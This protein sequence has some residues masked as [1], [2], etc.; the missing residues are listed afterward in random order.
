MISRPQSNMLL[1]VFIFAILIYGTYIVKK[2]DF[3]KHCPLLTLAVALNAI[4]IIFVMGPSFVTMVTALQFSA[5]L[6]PLVLIST[7][8]SVIGVIVEVLGMLVILRMK[9]VIPVIPGF[10]NM[11]ETMVLTMR[12]WLIAMILGIYIYVKIN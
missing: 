9:N 2:K 4:S 1:Q 12:M 8:H 7:F 6:Q 10:R 5:F 11:K 3:K